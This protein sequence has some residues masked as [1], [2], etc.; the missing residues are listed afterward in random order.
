MLS[1][2][3][4]RLIFFVTKAEL[5]T[6]LSLSLIGSLFYALRPLGFRPYHVMFLAPRP[7]IHSDVYLLPTNPSLPVYDQCLIIHTSIF[8]LLRSTDMT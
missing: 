1:Y 3:D 5:G 2:R 7:R 6:P 4:S 8:L